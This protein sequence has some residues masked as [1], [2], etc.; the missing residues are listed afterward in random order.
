MRARRGMTLIEILVAM[1]IFSLLLGSL[2]RMLSTQTRSFD[3]GTAD[4]GM[5]Q[6]LG[7][8]S[9]VFQQEFV[10]AGAGVPDAQPPVVYAG[11]NAFILNADYASNTDSLSPA[12]YNPGLPTGQ[13]QALTA[14]QRFVLPGTNPGFAYPDSNYYARGS[15]TLNS[16]AETISWWFSPDSSTDASTDWVLFRQVNAQPPEPVVRNIIQT[17]GR[18][19]FRYYVQKVPTTGTSTATLDT[20]PTS[21][22]PLKHSAGYHGSTADVGAAALIDS[23]AR[24]EVNFTVTNGQTGSALRSRAI[25]FSVPLPNVGTRAAVAC[26]NPPLSSA[27]SAGWVINT[28]VTPYDTAMVLTWPRSADEVGGENDV[29]SYVI[30]RRV[31]GTSNWNDPIA[32]VGAGPATPSW[33]DRS[34][35]KAA[36]GYDY[37]LA[38]QDCTPALSSMSTSSPPATP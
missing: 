16:P 20:V 6:N 33:T 11:T 28:G 36:P 14:A 32:T 2:L 31:R 22:M 24:V 18:N 19:F 3:S 5:T 21:L 23:V 15:T 1:T 26:G 4:M 35:V 30:W 25:N 7:Y 13:V 37:A 12:F 29:R 27:L 38:A 10:L 17:Q 8:A 9:T 34:A